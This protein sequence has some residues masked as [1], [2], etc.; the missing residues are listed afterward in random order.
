MA[1]KADGIRM[2]DHAIKMYQ[3]QIVELNAEAETI[4]QC[5]NE[6]KAEYQ[7]ILERLS[8]GLLPSTKAKTLDRAARET[9]ATFL[10]QKWNEL[11][12]S[13]E[14]AKQ[15][16]AQIDAEPRYQQHNQLIHPL[17]GRYP[18][19]LRKWEQHLGHIR[20][21][22]EKFK[23][24]AFWYLYSREVHLRRPKQGFEKFMHVVT[25]GNLRE[26]RAIEACCKEFNVPDFRAAAT[27]YE[28][29]K[30]DEE[31]ALQT[32]FQI[33]E[34]HDSV[35]ELIKEREKYFSW[36]TNFETQSLEEMRKVQFDFLWQANFRQILKQI[37]P[38]AKG[39]VGACHA[40]QEKTRYLQQ[41]V[42]YLE[43]EIKDR[44]KRKTSISRVRV[45][46]SRKPY[47]WLGGDKRKWL[48][49]LPEMMAQGTGKKLN[50]IRS[51]RNNVHG[52]RHYDRYAAMMEHDEQFLPYDLFGYSSPSAMPYE[53]F[54]TV[55]IHELKDHRRRHRQP[56]ANYRP[57]RSFFKKHKTKVHHW[58]NDEDYDFENEREH[59]TDDTNNLIIASSMI[60]D[61]NDIDLGYGGKEEQEDNEIDNEFHDVEDIE[62]E[63]LFDDDEQEGLEAEAV[64]A[65]ADENSTTDAYVENPSMFS[66]VS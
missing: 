59:E 26:N 4:Q 61:I 46:W 2:A 47:G 15:R 56:K 9:G 16:V 48:V 12:Q 29:L 64:S 36:V 11:Q 10:H 65:L 42:T 20:A 60:D 19:Q 18:Q 13:Y 32:H 8:I 30:M 49:A 27:M 34:A 33:R 25:L 37:R 35:V 62:P 22:K 58:E 40:L 43:K 51:M 53:G 14:R 3:Q 17:Q 5:M 50:W 44:T 54:S 21:T 38:A 24:E 63:D 1:T 45:K 23:L 28:R 55:V 31:Q 52:F 41:M 6:A 57:F 7:N 66:D 39:M